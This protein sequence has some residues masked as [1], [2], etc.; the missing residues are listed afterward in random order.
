MLGGARGRSVGVPL[1]IFARAGLGCGTTGT[2]GTAI[3]LAGLFAAV[4]G[5]AHRDSGWVTGTAEA[6]EGP[7]EVVV[8]ARDPPR[9]GPSHAHRSPT[10]SSRPGYSWRA[11][12]RPGARRGCRACA[13]TAAGLR[14]RPP[15]AG[16]A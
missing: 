7:P 14:R 3:D 11:R 15:E 12:R 13:P 1:R 4:T 5:T 6:G 8:V 10:G 2:T 16:R 9:H